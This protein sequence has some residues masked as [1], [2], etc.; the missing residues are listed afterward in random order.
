[1]PN[2]NQ[3]QPSGVPS[4][5]PPRRFRDPNFILEMMDKLAIPLAVAV[6]GFFFTMAE[7]I[8]NEKIA[9]AQIES[10]NKIANASITTNR[11]VEINKLVKQLHSVENMKADQSK[12]KAAA[13][14]LVQFGISNKANNNTK[15]IPLDVIHPL[16]FSLY[17]KDVYPE[18]IHALRLIG[19]NSVNVLVKMANSQTNLP[20][21]VL[22]AIQAIGK[23]GISTDSAV[24]VLE[25]IQGE[26]DDKHNIRRTNKIRVAAFIA[27][28]KLNNKSYAKIA[29]LRLNLNGITFRDHGLFDFRKMDFSDMKDINN[30]N[31]DGVIADNANFN[32]SR[33]SNNSKFRDASFKGANFNNTRIQNSD[34]SRSD[35]RETTFRGSEL[36]HINF[37][38]ADLRNTDFYQTNFK[39]VRF[40]QANVNGVD[41]SNAIFDN[42][43][44][45]KG[46]KSWENAHFNTTTEQALE[47]RQ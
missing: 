42:P 14:G 15:D 12:R 41:F 25:K 7:I 44:A 29:N 35:L 2:S 45:I 13:I 37:N 20:E 19:E 47:I 4:P 40:N 1:M 18:A 24:H 8:S 32:N 39:N 36:T 43:I 26:K 22:L 33:I 21:D 6:A 17:S 16:I 3:S 38:G 23:I 28:I 9:D 27:L 34:F 11:L 30:L 5:D 46:A 10:S 31:W